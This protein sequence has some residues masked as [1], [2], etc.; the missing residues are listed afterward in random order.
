MLYQTFLY[1]AYDFDIKKMFGAKISTNHTILQF[2]VQTSDDLKNMLLGNMSHEIK[3]NFYPFKKAINFCICDMFQTAWKLERNIARVGSI[4][5]SLMQASG[6][7]ECTV[8]LMMRAVGWWS[9]DG[10]MDR[11]RSTVTGGTIAA[12]SVTLTSTF[13]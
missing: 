12:A 9:S 3:V 13:G 6:Q 7:C 10:W 2:H 8:S 1:I 5:S 4:W 11:S